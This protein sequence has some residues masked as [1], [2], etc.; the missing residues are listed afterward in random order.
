MFMG[1]NDNVFFT[2]TS[3]PMPR[4]ACDEGGHRACYKL[5]SQYQIKIKVTVVLNI[6]S[7][8]FFQSL[9]VT[10]TVQFRND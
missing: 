3:A 10:V 5:K 2:A 6:E 4:H 9:I 8:E 1:I 7:D